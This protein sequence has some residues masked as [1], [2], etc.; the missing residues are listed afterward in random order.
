MSLSQLCSCAS[1]F[2]FSR[3]SSSGRSLYV[4]AAPMRC[5]PSFQRV[6]TTVVAGSAELVSG[7]PTSQ[8]YSFRLT[9]VG[10]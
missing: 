4:A 1:C 8:A 10:V 7:L 9:I 6:R 2:C 3:S 5:S